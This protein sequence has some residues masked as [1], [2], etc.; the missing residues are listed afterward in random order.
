MFS[1]QHR[2]ARVLFGLSDILLT[3]LAFEAAYQTRILLHLDRGFFLDVPKKA[4]G[5]GFSLAASGA[6]GLW[7][8][9]YGQLDS[10]GPRGS[11]GDSTRRRGHG[12]ICA[13]SVQDFRRQY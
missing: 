5:L 1:R 3:A 10:G 11:L 7:L 4:L 12:I 8:G 9:V 2:K 6:L 13:A